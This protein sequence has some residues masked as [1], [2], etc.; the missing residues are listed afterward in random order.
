MQI[1]DSMAKDKEM[2]THHKP[3]FDD[4][5]AT[6]LDAICCCV[7]PISLVIPFAIRVNLEPAVDDVVGYSPTSGLAGAEE[8]FI[9]VRFAG[10]GV[11][12]SRF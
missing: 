6:C 4:T 12:T 9:F 10:R 3:C 7:S 2:E 11:C 5:E 1:L 8:S